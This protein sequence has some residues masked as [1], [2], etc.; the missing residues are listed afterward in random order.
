[1]VCSPRKEAHELEV[2][3]DVHLCLLVFTEARKGQDFFPLL[4]ILA[5]LLPGPDKTQKYREEWLK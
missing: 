1:M 3:L 5:I 2:D 4:G